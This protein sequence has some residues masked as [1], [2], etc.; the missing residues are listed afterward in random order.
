MAL[1][2]ILQASGSDCSLLVVGHRARVVFPSRQ[3]VGSER[4]DHELDMSDLWGIDVPGNVVV[5]HQREKM[6]QRTSDQR[7]LYSWGDA[8]EGESVERRRHRQERETGR[9]GR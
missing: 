3:G 5:R 6:V 1:G 4:I 2:T 8:G 7:G 9:V